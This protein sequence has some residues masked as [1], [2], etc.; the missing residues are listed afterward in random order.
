MTCDGCVRSIRQAVA[1]LDPAA[2]VAADLASHRVTIDSAT[3]A[4]A[5]AEALRDAGFSPEMAPA[6]A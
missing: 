4:P 3:P 5:L 1:A 2:S 6:G